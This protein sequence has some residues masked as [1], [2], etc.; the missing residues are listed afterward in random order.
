MD[1]LY[2]DNIVNSVRPS[3]ASPSLS[4][5]NKFSNLSSQQKNISSLSIA[6]KNERDNSNTNMK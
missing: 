5:K 3:Y 6:D 2:L 4:P 1:R